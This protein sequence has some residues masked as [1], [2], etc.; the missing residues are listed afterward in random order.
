MATAN[1]KKIGYMPCEGQR[2]PSHERNIPVA[3][4]ENDKKTLSYCC[5][6]CG[7]SPYA[8]VGTGQHSEWLNDLTLDEH[9]TEPERSTTQPASVAPVAPSAEDATAAAPAPA[10]QK[11]AG[12]SW[13]L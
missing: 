9:R 1:K 13:A 7:R 12:L 3:V 8:K 6:E 5:F 10:K 2:C 11:K 4:F